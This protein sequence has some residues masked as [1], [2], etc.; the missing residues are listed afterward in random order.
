MF[1]FDRRTYKDIERLNIITMGEAEAHLRALDAA[2]ES[3]DLKWLEQIVSGSSFED[4]RM[5]ADMRAS[6]LRGKSF[7]ERRR[8][9]KEEAAAKAQAE[10]KRAAAQAARKAAEE[11]QG[12]PEYWAKR[13]DYKACASCGPGAIPLLLENYLRENSTGRRMIEEGLL[14]F[15]APAYAP[16][17]DY[18]S[19]LLME[20]KTFTDGI[21][22][23]D[24]RNDGDR[25]NA[26]IIEKCSEALSGSINIVGQF[27]DPR[28]AAYIESFYDF[29]KSNIYS[30]PESGFS[31]MFKAVNVR[32]GAVSAMENVRE[33]ELRNIV[34]AFYV[35]VLSDPARFVRWEAVD[36]LHKQ[37]QPQQVKKYPALREALEKA[38]KLEDNSVSNRKEKLMKL[39]A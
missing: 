5:V 4:V 18:V 8:I 19:G 13:G 9:L 23:L 39:L 38:L 37:F 15:G 16:T 35:K 7:W 36:I 21:S 29:V 20:Y 2:R 10:A 22:K 32:R 12:T 30:H 6:K 27:G 3:T 25:R 17:R 31:D 28:R 1:F 34:V 26:A 14:S 33:E 24:F 11:S